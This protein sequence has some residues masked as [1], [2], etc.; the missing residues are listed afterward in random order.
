MLQSRRRPAVQ[1]A[2]AAMVLAAAALSGPAPE[3][4][5]LFR[6]RPGPM[7]HPLAIGAADFDRDGHDDLV[8]ARYQAAVL[9]LLVGRGDGTFT[10]IPS[11]PIGVGTATLSTPT[12]GPFA[13][14]VSDL[15]PNDVDSDTI[16]NASDNCP[17]FP[18]GPELGTD[19]QL[20]TN[21]YGVGDACRKLKDTD[22]DG[23][24][25]AP[26]DTDGDGIP[27]YD[28]TTHR[29]DNCPRL[30]NP[31]QEDTE[32]AKGPDGLCGTKDDNPLLYGTDG[33]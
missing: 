3:A 12:T 25:D 16:P 9:D 7:D 33:L 27:D 17:N 30:P 14:I 13:L 11:G 31:G 24:G 6:P 21:N 8:V 26:I 20:D 23:V 28:P 19:S 32:T 22:A 29:L 1:A 5:P 10:P 15:N 4:R 18:N 2:V